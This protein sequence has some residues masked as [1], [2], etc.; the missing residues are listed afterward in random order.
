M[1]H[2]ADALTLAREPLHCGGLVAAG[3][4]FERA[5]EVLFCRL[6]GADLP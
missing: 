1:F 3:Q 2:L 5:A 6:L 4:L